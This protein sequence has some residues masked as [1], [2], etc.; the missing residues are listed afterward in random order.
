MSEPSNPEDCNGVSRAGTTVAQR[1]ERRDARAHQRTCFDCAQLFRNQR[2][3]FER[4]DDVLLVTAIHRYSGN[5]L[6]G[7]RDETAT[8][9]RFAVTAITAQPT[10][11]DTLPR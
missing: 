4:H 6:I 3:S 1:V 2:Q 11:S 5:Q 7:A 8:P 10:D 9:A